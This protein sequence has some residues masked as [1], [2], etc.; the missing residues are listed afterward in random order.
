MEALVNPF[1]FSQKSED[2]KKKDAIIKVNDFIEF[3]KK[4]R[5]Y[6]DEE[7][8]KILVNITDKFNEAHLR[9][10]FKDAVPGKA[11]WEFFSKAWENVSKDIPFLRKKLEKEFRLILGVK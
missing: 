7:T 8:C 4:N 1:S 9:Y 5:I 6:F 3:S 11:R 10:T 2:E